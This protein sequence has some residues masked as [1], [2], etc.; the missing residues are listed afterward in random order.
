M[1]RSRK[2]RKQRK[3]LNTQDVQDAEADEP[4]R[5]TPDD[6]KRAIEAAIDEGDPEELVGVVIDVA[7]AS[8]DL[9]WATDRCLQLAHDSDAT[10]RGNALTAL[11]HLAERFGELDEAKV[12]PAMHAALADAKEHVREQAEAAL[13]TLVETL[14]WACEE[15]CEGAGQRD[16]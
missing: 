9:A 2:E 1:S 5:E 8:D 11:T 12:R 15:A 14:G 6:F 3:A 10:V 4:T 7:M 13:E 16:G